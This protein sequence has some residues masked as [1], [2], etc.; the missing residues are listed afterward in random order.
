MPSESPLPSPVPVASSAAPTPALLTPTVF[1]AGIIQGSQA[2]IGIEAQEYRHVLRAALCEEAAFPNAT[3]IDPVSDHPAS[4]RYTDAQAHDCFYTNLQF[5]ARADILVAYLPHASMG[6][7]IELFEAR[8]HRGFTVVITPMT[9]NWVVRLMA[10]WVL[11]DLDAFQRAC[12]R[13]DL[14]DHYF[15]H[16]GVTEP[17]D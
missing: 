14:R 9:H 1:L 4:P 8:R 6:T 3:V 2:G 13:G 16:L 7:G 10:R 15:R 12:Q 17:S 5:A 11:P